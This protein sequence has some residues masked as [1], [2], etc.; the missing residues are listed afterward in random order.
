[1]N[2]AGSPR[3]R[4]VIFDV[5]GVLVRTTDPTSR[6]A[7][8]QRL[9][10][11]AGEAE[12]LVFNSPMG[13]RAQMGAIPACELWSWV[14][15]R[16]ELDE[17]GLREF[18]HDFFAGDTLDHALLGYVRG[19]RPRYQ[20][21]II[22]NAMDSLTETLTTTYPMT[23]AFDLIVGSAY[24][25][26]MKPDATIFATALSRLGREPGEAVFVD[27]S[28]ANVDGARAAGLHAVQ[29]VAGMDLAD[30]LAKLG[31]K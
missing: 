23:D 18:Q 28:A 6:R 7:L 31:V 13:T 29:Y 19:L 30:T 14:Q 2:R 21:A 17:E 11:A 3:I 15:A 4:A 26:V 20:T 25:K 8:E 5:G 1:M 16:L 24:V 22:S 27:D 12:Y 10:L 9:G